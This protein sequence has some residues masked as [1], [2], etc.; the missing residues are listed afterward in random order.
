MRFESLC[1]RASRTSC[2]DV[3]PSPA[4]GRRPLPAAA[5]SPHATASYACARVSL[6]PRLLI[7]PSRAGASSVRSRRVRRNIID[8]HT[9]HVLIQSRAF[10]WTSRSG[11][12]ALSLSHDRPRYP[13]PPLTPFLR[14]SH[15]G[16]CSRGVT[17]GDARRTAATARR[18]SSDSEGS[19]FSL[20][21]WPSPSDGHSSGGRGDRL[22]NVRVLMR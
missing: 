3:P 19:W 11:S 7:L 16:R 6:A 12:L 17:I 5:F 10:N 21:L 18:Q 4:T 2:G 1:C 15:N 8:T 13:S 20:V 9:T 22:P 14:R